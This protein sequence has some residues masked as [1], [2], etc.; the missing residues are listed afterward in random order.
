M[1]DIDSIDAVAFSITNNHHRLLAIFQ[2]IDS[3]VKNVA[4]KYEPSAGLWHFFVDD[5]ETLS[6]LLSEA[7]SHGLA[8]LE[9][10]NQV[11]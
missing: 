2:Q 6:P 3:Q 1:A 8:L 11:S 5:Q 4:Y 9:Q 10:K 7:I